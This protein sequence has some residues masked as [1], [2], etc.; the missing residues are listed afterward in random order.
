MNVD[1][2]KIQQSNFL[3]H[4]RAQGKS[5]NSLKCYRL[6]FN[7]VND[8][9]IKHSLAKSNQFNFDISTTQ[10]FE[11][12]LSQRYPNIN[13]VRRKLQTMRLFFDYLVAKNLITSNPIKAIQSS[14]KVLYPPT[15]HPMSDIQQ[16]QLYLVFKIKNSASSKEKIQNFRNYVLFLIIYHSGLSV[17]Q[18]ATLKRE[19]FLGLEGNGEIRILIST[20]KRDPFSVPFPE[21]LRS[22]LTEYF[23]LLSSEMQKDDF[24]FNEIFFNSNAYKL[25]SGGIS[26]RGLED[27][28]NKISESLKLE[29]TPKS[30]RQTAI[31]HW[32]AQ[33][34]NS[35]TIKEWLGVAPSYNM[36]LYLKVFEELKTECLKLTALEAIK[37]A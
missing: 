21:H 11:H 6:D 35:T 19:N 7:C 36:S 12:F 5:E 10:E 22:T 17:S 15:L 16:T 30:L 32:V 20:E 34:H 1:S 23:S 37:I 3:D 13:S 28:F 9:L 18:L 29:I 31:L 25:I 8:F 33:N 26:A 14:P 2:F 24:F 4:Y 27:I